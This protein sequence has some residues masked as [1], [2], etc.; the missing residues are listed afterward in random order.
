MYLLGKIQEYQEKY[1][2]KETNQE[3]HHLLAMISIELFLL[4]QYKIRYERLN[5]KVNNDRRL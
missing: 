3:L 4:T 1:N 5:K 2:T